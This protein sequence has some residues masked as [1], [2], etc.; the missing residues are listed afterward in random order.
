[1]PFNTY[2]LEQMVAAR[3]AEAR[4]AAQRDALVRAARRERQPHCRWRMALA[5]CWK[6]IRP[7]R[8]TSR[9]GG[10]PGIPAG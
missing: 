8:L 9:L 6:A 10:H 3:L 1:M 5:S 7:S 4:A 2:T